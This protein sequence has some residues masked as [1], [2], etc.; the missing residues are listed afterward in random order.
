MYKAESQ[1]PS[2]REIVSSGWHTQLISLGKLGN[3][4]KAWLLNLIVLE[5]NQLVIIRG[6]LVNQM[7]LGMIFGVDSQQA[8][9]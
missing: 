8:E 5:A 9:T 6:K 4:I 1:L 7:S 3:A 2:I